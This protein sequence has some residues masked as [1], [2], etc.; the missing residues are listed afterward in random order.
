MAVKVDDKTIEYISILAKLEL[1]EAEKETAKQDMSQMLTYIGELN[2][3][4]TDETEPMTHILPIRNRFREDE[5]T[6][7]EDRENML[8][9]APKKK[10]GSFQVPKTID[11][12]G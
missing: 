8:A 4:N 11:F 12:Q 7:P 1:S 5:I 6:N 10:E 2:K 3:L 9:N